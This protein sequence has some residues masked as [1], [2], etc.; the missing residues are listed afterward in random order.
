MPDWRGIAGRRLAPLAL[1]AE[2]KEEI[3]DE[4]SGHLEDL[5]SDLLRHG[6]SEA[7][8]VRS[9]LSSV[10]DWDEL[11]D[12][13]QLAANEEAGM[14]YRLGPAGQR[15]LRTLW[16]PGVCTGL[17]SGAVLRLL[18]F[19]PVT[20][21]NVSWLGYGTPLVI[22]WQWYLCLLLIGAMGAYCSR[23]AGG[24]VRERALAASFPALQMI[25]WPGIVLP[26]VMIFDLIA[27]HRAPLLVA[28]IF[29]LDW[30]V[31]PEAALLLGALPF[32][33]GDAAEPHQAAT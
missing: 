32:L 18:P 29:L 17:L 8:A 23:R 24:T 1:E 14:D 12:E 30:I 25:C 10:A 5:Y 9:A 26:F 28:A 21:P 7:E 31:L 4:L 3:I 15:R 13:I 16:L 27:Y 20:S 19:P 11:R 22:Y 2:R 33:T 6:K